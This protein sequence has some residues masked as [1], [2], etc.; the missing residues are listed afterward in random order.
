MRASRMKTDIQYAFLCACQEVVLRQSELVPALARTLRVAPQEV[1]YHW[2]M[3]P[4]C[5][6]TGTIAGSSWRF[7]FHG[8]ECD[9]KNPDGRFLRVDFGPG[10]R[11]DAFTGW[12]VLQ[13]VMTSKAPWREYP[14]LR[15]H[16]AEGLPPF[17][18]LS[19]SHERMVSLFSD[20]ADLG[21][22]EVASAK[23][24]T[25]EANDPEK[26]AFWDALVCHVWIL[27]ELGKQT[28]AGRG[29]TS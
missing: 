15:R 8:L 26:Q 14:E 18:E 6:Q 22:V 5:R 4:R 28:L 23:I 27:S 2:A 13:F 16:L 10:G 29:C 20:L 11:F 12:G 17:D 7:F 21:L 19:G 24:G 9:L 3:P 1:F 25:K